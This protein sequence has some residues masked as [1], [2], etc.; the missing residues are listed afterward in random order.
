MNAS[1]TLDVVS[2]NDYRCA[3]PHPA[4]VYNSVAFNELNASKVAEVRHIVF[5]KGGKPRLGLTVGVCHDGSLRAPFS[6]PFACFDFNKEQC[7][8]VMVGAVGLLRRDYAGLRLTLPPAVYAPSMTAKTVLA[9]NHCGARLLYDDW[10]FHLPLSA[11]GGYGSLVDSDTRR[12]VTIAA[13][14]GYELLD[15]TDSPGRAYSVVAANHQAKGYP[16]HMSESQVV[17]TAGNGG[18]VKGRFFVLTDGT[19]DAA[20]AIVYDVAPGISQVIYWG[21]SPEHGCG[22]AMNL[23]AA[24]LY[25][26]YSGQGKSILDIGPS[27]S[28]GVPSAGL[29]N[30]KESIGCIVSSKPTF[31]L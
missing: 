9:L 29:C 15:V 12:V 1:L 26:Y 18:P 13:R 22:Y 31:Q 30:F 3:F 27:S 11:P 10:N 21:D 7:V 4:V 28:D 24:R 2:V 14:C 19:E 20:A 25:D 6:A 23:L 17:A 5:T 8:E 16:M